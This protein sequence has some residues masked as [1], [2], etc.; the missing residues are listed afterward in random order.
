MSL[1]LLMTAARSSR[2]APRHPRMVRG[3][4]DCHAITTSDMLAAIGEPQV[5]AEQTSA[6]FLPRPA[7]LPNMRDSLVRRAAIFGPVDVDPTSV[8]LRGP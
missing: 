8:A 2:P 7:P 5:T 6:S 4:S 1:S 3:G